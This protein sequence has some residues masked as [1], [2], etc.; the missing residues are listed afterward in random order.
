MT[1]CVHLWLL[2]PAAS[3][4]GDCTGPRWGVGSSIAL[5]PPNCLIVALLIFPWL[6]HL[7]TSPCP[8]VVWEPEWA[9][10]SSHQ[11][12]WLRP[13]CVGACEGEILAIWTQAVLCVLPWGSENKPS[14]ACL[15]YKHRCSNY[16]TLTIVRKGIKY[17]DTH[18]KLFWMVSFLLCIHQGCF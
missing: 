10:N 8:G 15:I 1:F 7:L 18:F 6:C 5:H 16:S 14:L 2:S 9:S 17:L 12:V 11:A 4:L 13:R 3:V